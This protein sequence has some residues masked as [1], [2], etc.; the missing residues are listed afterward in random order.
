MPGG[1]NAVEPGLLST[2]LP[3]VPFLAKN[4]KNP[5]RAVKFFSETP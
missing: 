5:A 3:G 4:E 2:P 1:V